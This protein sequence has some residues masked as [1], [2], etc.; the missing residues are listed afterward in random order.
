MGNDSQKEPADHVPPSGNDPGKPCAGDDNSHVNPRNPQPREGYSPNDQPNEVNSVRKWW[1]FGAWLFGKI[2]EWN[3]SIALV[4]SALA[5]GLTVWS[6]F[7]FEGPGLVPLAFRSE[8]SRSEKLSTISEELRAISEML[9]ERSE[10]SQDMSLWNSIDTA[11]RQLSRITNNHTALTEKVIDNKEIIK[12]LGEMIDN[13][14]SVHIENIILYDG[15]KSYGAFQWRDFCQEKDRS[16]CN[17]KL[18]F[19]F[20]KKAGSCTG[21]DNCKVY[22]PPISQNENLAVIIGDLASREARQDFGNILSKKQGRKKHLLFYCTTDQASFADRY[23]IRVNMSIEQANDMIPEDANQ[24]EPTICLVDDSWSTEIC[25]KICPE[26]KKV[27]G[28]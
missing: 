26:R 13:L 2:G 5:L 25:P 22:R 10:D 27:S 7:V 23:S 3:S 12:R 24:K 19:R 15:G 16:Y 20:V 4:L 17:N 21:E 11:S 18:D 1:K 14:H 28:T 9:G 6:N 8:V